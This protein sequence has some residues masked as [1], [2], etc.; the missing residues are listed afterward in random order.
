MI[1]ATESDV[2]ITD[3]T[4]GRRVEMQFSVVVFACT[5]ANVARHFPKL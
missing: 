4:T 1:Y 5:I 2:D 3:S